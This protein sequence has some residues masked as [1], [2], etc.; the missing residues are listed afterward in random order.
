MQ[1]MMPRIKEEI[2]LYGNQ[3]LNP[4]SA[5]KVTRQATAAAHVQWQ[6]QRVRDNRAEA[7]TKRAS[8]YDSRKREKLTASISGSGAA[9]PTPRPRSAEDMTAE[10]ADA[11]MIR[12]FGDGHRP[13]RH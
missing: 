12:E 3:N 1:A 5:E 6:L 4:R 11:A 9:A 10:E 2:G 8:Q 7:V 13:R